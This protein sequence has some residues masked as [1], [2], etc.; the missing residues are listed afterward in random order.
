[1]VL[2]ARVEAAGGGGS[3]RRIHDP[4]V[5]VGLGAGGPPI[6]VAVFEVLTEEVVDAAP[7]LQY[8]GLQSV[9]PTTKP[10]PSALHVVATLPLQ[11]GM[12]AVQTLVLHVP[13][14]ASQYSVSWQVCRSVDDVA[15]HA[16]LPGLVAR[17]IAL[18]G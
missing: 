15:F 14:A 12:L 16:A 11:A 7:A 2:L 5:S 4:R 13:V 1:M 17:A 6:E 3:A 9:P 18:A 8:L 10:E